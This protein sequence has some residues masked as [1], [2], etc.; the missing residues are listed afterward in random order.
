MKNLE[1]A[2]VNE[3]YQDDMRRGV[4]RVIKHATESLSEAE[5]RTR[6]SAEIEKLLAR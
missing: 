4:A 1:F 6:A 3:R 5:A 2:I